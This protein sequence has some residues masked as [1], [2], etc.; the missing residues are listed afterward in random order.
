[1]I[2][3]LSDEIDI[4]IFS[5]KIDGFERLSFSLTKNA[6]INKDK[7]YYT[8]LSSL[9]SG[10]SIVYDKEIQK[11]NIAYLVIKKSED[12]NTDVKQ[13]I[14][15][16]FTS[17]IVRFEE[18]YLEEWL[19]SL[20]NNKLQKPKEDNET[21]QDVLTTQDES[22]DNDKDKNKDDILIY[23]EKIDSRLC[24]IENFLEILAKPTRMKIG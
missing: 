20:K 3:V 21:K 24:N 4:D 19:D 8:Q 17:V 10:V 6:L 13:T 1:M 7:K 9:N 18:L 22:F 14:T 2:V 15:N 11:I 12:K 23:L 5:K 16:I